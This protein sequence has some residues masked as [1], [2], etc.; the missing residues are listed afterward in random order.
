MT[1]PLLIELK[2]I[3]E[4][5]IQTPCKFMFANL[6]EANIN[7]DN[8]R[9]ST[10]PVALFISREHNTFRLMENSAKINR[11]VSIMLH[12]LD[13]IEQ[14]TFE[15]KTEEANDVQFKCQEIAHTIIKQCMISPF[16]NNF[17]SDPITRW[18]IV[19]T[20][21]EFDENLY[22]VVL[23]FDWNTIIKKG[24]C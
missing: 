5:R 9:N 2:Q 21:S 16:S 11:T 18:S 12:I 20:F 19:D 14:P 1:D 3:C 24:Y 23:T 4:S 7:L 13:R 10:I 8:I 6:F 15:S 17:S 22:G